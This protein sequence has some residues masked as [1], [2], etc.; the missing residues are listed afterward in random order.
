VKG[1]GRGGGGR[2]WWWEG[3]DINQITQRRQPF[4]HGNTRKIQGR[5]VLLQA[6]SHVQRHNEGVREVVLAPAILE[7]EGNKEN[8]RRC[9]DN[10]TRILPLIT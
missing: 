9:R 6:G 1:K 5:Q 7:K 4:M 8:K 3:I 10:T 2:P